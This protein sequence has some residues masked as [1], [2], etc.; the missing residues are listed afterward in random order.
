MNKR[1]RAVLILVAI[2]VAYLEG[3]AKARGFAD[4][5][6]KMNDAELST[7]HAATSGET[8]RRLRRRRRIP[9]APPA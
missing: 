7:L 5:M 9:P 1:Q 4:G 6:S 8:R 2:P 3:W